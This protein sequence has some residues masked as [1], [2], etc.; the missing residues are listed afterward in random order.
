[1]KN[2]KNGS[3]F[4]FLSARKLR[5]KYAESMRSADAY[6]PWGPRILRVFS[7]HSPRKAHARRMCV[8]PRDFPQAI[9][10]G[11]KVGCHN[12][13][14]FLVENCVWKIGCTQ[15]QV[16]CTS[17]FALCALHTHTPLMASD[18]LGATQIPSSHLS[19]FCKMSIRIWHIEP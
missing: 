4:K 2:Q 5:G 7:A 17:H 10:W 16:G 18:I 11:G 19:E 13:G 15:T 6:S 8:S 3:F 9:P 14:K 12:G 1:M